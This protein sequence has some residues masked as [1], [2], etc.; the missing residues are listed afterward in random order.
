MTPARAEALLQGQTSLARKVFDATPIQESWTVAS[1]RNA[2]SGA[3][4]TTSAHVIRGCLRELIDAGLVRQPE[5]NQFQRVEIRAAAKPQQQEPAMPAAAQATPA[6]PSIPAEQHTPLEL[7]GE[8]AGE[9]GALAKA[10]AEQLHNMARRIEEVALVVEQDREAIAA[11]L[12]KLRQ[13]QAL[14]KSM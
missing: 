7:L 14:L 13:F 11:D 8:L 3:S 2:L 5:R 12:T 6:P 1:I 4:M 9:M 10:M